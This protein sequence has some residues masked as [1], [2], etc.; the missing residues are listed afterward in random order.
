MPKA[1]KKRPIILIVIIVI[2]VIAIAGAYLL[3]QQPTKTVNGK[4]GVVVYST[5]HPSEEPIKKSEY[6]STAGPTEPKYIT[7]PTIKAEGFIE[8]I[9]VDQNTQMAVPTNINLAGWYVEALKPGEQGLSIIDRHL[10]GYKHD[11]IFKNL[12]KLKPGQT[13]VVERGDGKKLTY[14]VKSVASVPTDQAATKLFAHDPAIKSQLNLI[15][16]GGKFDEAKKQYENRVIV[17]SE[18]Q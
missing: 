16:C 15:T 14:Q 12:E 2:A 10:D 18:L 3:R 9:G 7:L 6:K 13:Y 11:G 5:D 17:V 8:K 4:K 1:S